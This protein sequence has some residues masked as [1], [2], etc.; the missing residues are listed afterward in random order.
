[1]RRSRV[2]PKSFDLTTPCPE[3]GYKVPPNELMPLDRERMRCPKCGKDV[4]IA[5]NQSSVSI[6][7]VR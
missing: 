3:C 4:N 6:N 5:T 1:M 7:P 2:D